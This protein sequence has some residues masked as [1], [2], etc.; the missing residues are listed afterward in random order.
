MS[1]SINYFLLCFF[2]FFLSPQ[3]EVGLGS[4]PSGIWVVRLADMRRFVNLPAL[5]ALKVVDGLLPDGK[6]VFLNHFL[7]AKPLSNILNGIL[8]SFKVVLS[9]FPPF[10]VLF[11]VYGGSRKNPITTGP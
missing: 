7:P 3:V 6:V 5:D 10:P 8:L 1:H 2:F 11:P 4:I 9:S